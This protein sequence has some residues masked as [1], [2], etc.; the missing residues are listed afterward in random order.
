MKI[1]IEDK[2]R[3]NEMKNIM[4]IPGVNEQEVR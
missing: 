4:K 1:N 3:I 2:K